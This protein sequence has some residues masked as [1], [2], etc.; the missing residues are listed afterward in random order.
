MSY[1]LG[2]IWALFGHGKIILSKIKTFSWM[3]S[4]IYSK[5]YIREEHN[6]NYFLEGLWTEFR[7]LKKIGNTSHIQE[8][9]RVH[10]VSRNI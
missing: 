8:Q 3:N 2:F 9:N 10:D 4:H 6:L 7:K 5:I 1:G